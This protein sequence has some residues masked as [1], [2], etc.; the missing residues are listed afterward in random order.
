MVGN[1][2]AMTLSVA[3]IGCLIALA[4]DT[5]IHDDYPEPYDDEL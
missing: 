2:L 3:L 4:I 1:I 5:I